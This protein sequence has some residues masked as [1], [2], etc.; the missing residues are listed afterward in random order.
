MLGNAATMAEVF[1]DCLDPDDA[2]EP[3]LKKTKSMMEE[4]AVQA[5]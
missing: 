5:N 1:L 3:A 4:Q 2:E